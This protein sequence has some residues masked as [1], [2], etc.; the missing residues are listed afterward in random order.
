MRVLV[1]NVGSTSFKFRLLAM[2]EEDVEAEGRVERVGTPGSM[3]IFRGRAGRRHEETFD[4]RD[5]AEAI[6][7]CLG[8]LTDPDIGVIAGLDSLDAVGFK[9]VHA[10]GI[11]G[12]VIV[13]EPVIGAMR[14]YATVAPAHNGPYIEAF[15]IFMELLPTVPLVGVFEPWFHQTMP[16]EAQVYAVPF[17]WLERHGIRRYGFHGASHSYVASRVARLVGRPVAELRTISCHLGGSSSICAIRGGVSVDTS[18]GFSPQSGLPNATRIGDLDPYAVLYVMDREGL[19]PGEMAAVL[20]TDGGL[21]GISG[22][23]GDLRDI[24]AAAAEGNRRA[25]LA[26]DAF[27]YAAR[28]YIG[29]YHAI[30]GGLDVLAFTGGIGEHSAEMRAR[31]CRGLDHLGLELDPSRNAA[32]PQEG[33]VSSGRSPAAIAVVAANE[34]LVIARETV[35]LLAATPG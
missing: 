27:A 16:P 11:A 31:I 7:R 8:L 22:V 9:P 24:E 13:D 12:A 2:P 15:R 14:D 26:L 4:C 33:L 19:G 10:H 20:A 1:A 30:L 32:S 29:A 21:K 25:S 6:G 17:E 28:K 35:R 5:H 18:M 23:G 34:E 3:L